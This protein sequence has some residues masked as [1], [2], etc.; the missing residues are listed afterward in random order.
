[1]GIFRFKELCFGYANSSHNVTRTVSEVADPIDLQALDFNFAIKQIDKSI[2]KIVASQVTWP[3]DGQKSETP[4]ELAPCSTF[5]D[6]LEFSPY[7]LNRQSEYLCPV[8]ETL[9]IQGNESTDVQKYI[10]IRMLGCEPQGGT[11]LSIAEIANTEVDF[12]TL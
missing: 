5:V 11:C 10:E 7:S 4:V 1:M 6:D 8:V 2:G 12:L 9:L 3:A